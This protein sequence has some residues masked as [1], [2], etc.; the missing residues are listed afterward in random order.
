MRESLRSYGYLRGVDEK[1]M[2]VEAV[3][4]T[5][6]IARDQM[7]I[8][9]E[10]WD[11]TNYRRNPVVLWGHDDLSAPVART[12]G[13]IKR[14][15]TEL[16]A[17]AE[18]DREDPEAVRIFGKVKRGYVNATSVRW[19]PKRTEIRAIATEQGDRDTLV[20]IEQEL[21]EWSFVPIPADPGAMILRADGSSFD[22][23]A[24]L[25]AGTS[26]TS[27]LQPETLQER[28]EAL[29]DIID[30]DL[31]DEGRA[32]LTDLHARIAPVITEEVVITAPD[33]RVLRGIE[34]IAAGLE[35]VANRKPIDVDAIVIAA[36]A[37]ATGKS[38]E[39]VRAELARG[40]NG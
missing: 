38:K 39:R 13:E 14:T 33:D 25:R 26:P 27:A 3:I 9:P 15:T 30:D 21:L 32:L 29:L 2:T 17:T 18:F 1:A 5:G 28:I 11:F 7:I 19:L 40:I 24:A 22:L 31:D 12:V 36:M 34:Q 35:A 6:N 8:D 16:I 10:G 37:R 23:D 20:F 4:S